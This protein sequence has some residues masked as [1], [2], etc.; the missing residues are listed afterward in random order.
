[1]FYTIYKVTNNL[2]GK[3]YI[4]KH[5]TKDLDDA[6]MGSGK[7]LKRAIYHHGLENFTKEILFIFDNEEEMNRKEAELVTE[8]FVKE[9][10]NYN[11]CPG[12]KGGWGYINSEYHSIESRSELGRLGGFANR[13]KLSEESLNRIFAGCK[14]GGAASTHNFHEANRKRKLG[15]LENGFKNKKHSDEWKKKHSELM[16]EKQSGSK[17]SQFGVKKSKETI[18]KIKNTLKNK[19]IMRCKHC[20]FE[21]DNIGHLKRWHNDNCKNLLS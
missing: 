6:Y 19:P 1:M 18:E 21:S 2:D 17:N 14:K 11:L 12:G 16:K 4:G 15:F 9:N 7:W 13:D 3:F 8:E 20:D 5:Q 10:T